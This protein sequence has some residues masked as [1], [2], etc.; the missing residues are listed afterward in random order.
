[1]LVLKKKKG[2]LTIGE[3]IVKL[4]KNPNDSDPELQKLKKSLDYFYKGVAKQQQLVVLNF[5]KTA[6]AAIEPT[7]QLYSTAL[8]PIFKAPSLYFL[9]SI[10]R[11]NEQVQ[12]LTEPL[13]VLTETI[14]RLQAP[15]IY[16]VI[17]KLYGQQQG[18]TIDDEI[19]YPGQAL[20]TK[21]YTEELLEEQNRLLGH[22]VR[23]QQI[24]VKGK[25]YIF[26]YESGSFIIKVVN[27][28]SVNLNSISEKDDTKIF[29]RVLLGIM[30]EAGKRVGEFL[31]VF[32]P[33]GELVDRLSKMGIQNPSLDWIRR[34]KGNMVS[35]KLVPAEVES[36]IIISD[37]DNKQ[38]GYLFRM[39]VPLEK[40]PT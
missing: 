15:L 31:E 26:D 33:R 10:N 16:P 19:P 29:F 24:D 20:Q 23:I 5:S 17:P 36:I 35:K 40:L 14:A 12:L 6:L 13:R 39:K 3:A 38:N 9:E 21:T 27:W 32:I 11:F 7:L 22:L 37:Y 2:E 18:V 25:P 34:T 4:K 8:I 28:K 30:E 1:M